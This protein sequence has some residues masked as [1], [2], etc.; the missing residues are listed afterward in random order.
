MSPDASERRDVGR[1]LL[2]HLLA[3]FDPARRT[4]IG[5]AG[6]SGSGKSVTSTGLARTLDASGWPTVVLHLD[7]Y[8]VRPPRTNHEHRLLDLANVGPHEVDLARLEGDV[9]A[10]RAGAAGVRAPVVDYPGNRFVEEVISFA[11]SQVLIVEGTWALHLGD[12]D[13]RILLDATHEDTLERRRERNRDIDA[14]IMRDILAIEHTLVAP[15]RAKA[16][17]VIDRHFAISHASPA[18][19]PAS[20][21]Q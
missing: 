2:P 16:D 11:G 8:F 18:V 14:P 3:R 1:D 13:V 7:N 5:I 12:L 19:P 20:P 10:F 6:E 21:S 9:A 17:I 15:M 4:V